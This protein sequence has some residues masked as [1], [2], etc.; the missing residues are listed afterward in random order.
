MS[1]FRGGVGFQSSKRK[2]GKSNDLDGSTPKPDRITMAKWGWNVERRFEATAAP[3][4]TSLQVSGGPTATA[5]TRNRGEIRA[6]QR[7]RPVDFEKPS[8]G[9]SSPP[10]EDSMVRCSF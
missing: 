2:R 5:P 10:P 9:L 3:G 6:G 4:A 7:R 8:L 1:G